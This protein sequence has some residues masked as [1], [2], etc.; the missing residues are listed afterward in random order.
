MTK[1][2]IVY[3]TNGAIQLLKHIGFNTFKVKTL[4]WNR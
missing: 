2:Q 4:N 1:F 3:R